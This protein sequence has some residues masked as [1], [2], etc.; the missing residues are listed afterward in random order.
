MGTPEDG[1]ETG[2][3][4]GTITSAG[5]GDATRFGPHLERRD[6]AHELEL[7]LDDHLIAEKAMV[8]AELA[9]DIENIEREKAAYIKDVGETLKVKYATL[10]A[11]MK[12]IRESKVTMLVDCVEIRDF[13]MNAIRYEYEGK[14]YGERAMTVDER[15][16]EM[17]LKPEIP[18]S[19]RDLDGVAIQP[20]GPTAEER[21][22]AGAASCRH[23]P[24]RKKRPGAKDSGVLEVTFLEC[25]I[26]GDEIDESGAN[27]DPQTKDGGPAEAAPV[28]VPD[29]DPAA[30]KA[31]LLDKFNLGQLTLEEYEDQLKKLEAK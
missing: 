11:H 14:T 1:D 13:A 20:G 15:Q 3:A 28:E 31:K 29:G 19:L 21:E 27:V 26:C 6:V 12:A 18:D 17:P 30:A 23:V 22:E 24:V 8:A 2:P 9:E 4:P 16:M 7:P 25:K 10:T 5:D